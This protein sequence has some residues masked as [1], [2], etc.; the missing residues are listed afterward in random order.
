MFH[1]KRFLPSTSKGRSHVY[2]HKFIYSG[3]AFMKGFYDFESM[4]AKILN[5]NKVYNTIC[6]K[7]KL[8]VILL[9]V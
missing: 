7:I 4:G 8:Q 9:G 1:S 3:S 5:V 6:G 2:L